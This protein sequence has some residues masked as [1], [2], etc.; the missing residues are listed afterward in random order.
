MTH[1]CVI[2]AFDVIDLATSSPPVSSRLF[3]AAAAAADVPVA[4]IS[5]TAVVDDV[6]EKA[7]VSRALFSYVSTFIVGNYIEACAFGH[8]GPSVRL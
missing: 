8:W 6:I 1:A 3:S 7:H 4:M 2:D 5:S